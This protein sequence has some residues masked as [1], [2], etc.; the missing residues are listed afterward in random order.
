MEI[1][2]IRHRPTLGRERWIDI[3]RHLSGHL[4]AQFQD[5]SSHEIQHK[6]KQISKIIS[7]KFFRAVTHGL[8]DMGETAPVLVS[9]KNF[10]LHNK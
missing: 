5:P 10:K 7:I 4:F 9:I 1:F 3:S 6:T 8:I 2:Q